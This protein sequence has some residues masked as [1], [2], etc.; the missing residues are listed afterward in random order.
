MKAMTIVTALA[1]ALCSTAALAQQPP[2]KQT[3]SQSTGKPNSGKPNSHG[4]ATNPP[5]GNANAK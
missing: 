1:V 4:Q 2:A 3:Q 5:S